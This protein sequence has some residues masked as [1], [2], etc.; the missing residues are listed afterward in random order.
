M[1]VKH[2]LAKRLVTLAGVEVLRMRSRKGW[3]IESTSWQNL[4]EFTSNIILFNFKSLSKLFKRKHFNIL[5]KT[6]HSFAPFFP[7]HAAQLYNKL[8]VLTAKCFFEFHSV[9]DKIRWKHRAFSMTDRIAKKL[10]SFDSIEFD[11]TC[12]R[13]H[14]ALLVYELRPDLYQVG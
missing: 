2:K 6:F 13:S 7:S 3:A 1:M 8:N 10:M 12:W 14:E 4:Q 5:M 11:F 9:D